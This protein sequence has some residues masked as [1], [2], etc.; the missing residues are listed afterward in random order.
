MEDKCKYSGRDPKSF[1]SLD[2]VLKMDDISGENGRFVRVITAANGKKAFLRIYKDN[3]VYPY[4]SQISTALK[5]LLQE[6][7]M[8]GFVTGHK[9]RS[10]M[11][12]GEKGYGTF[13]S[14]KTFRYSLENSGYGVREISLEH[15]VAEDINIIVLADMRSDFTEEEFRNFDAYLERGGNLFIL[16]EPQ[17]SAV[18]ESGDRE[19]GVTF[20]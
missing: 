6:A 10:G 17:A 9:E 3:H 8:V 4:E 12:M 11:D 16:G 15:P 18:Y 5:T 20:R 14:N 13:A 2:E 19:I 7:P 1:L